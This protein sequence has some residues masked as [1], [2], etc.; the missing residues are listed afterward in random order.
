MRD[1][2]EQQ[3]VAQRR[4]RLLLLCMALS[5]VAMGGIVF[6]ALWAVRSVL[7]LR[8]PPGAPLPP[9]L[10]AGPLFFWSVTV[11][12]VV[13]AIAGLLRTL[14]LR[15]GGSSIAELLDARLVSGQPQDGLDRRLLNVVAE[16]ALAAGAPIPQVYV[17]DRELGI[18]AMAA[19]WDLGDSVICVTRGCLQRL[20]RSELQ[21][22]VAHEFSHLLHGDAR[23]N[24]RLMGAVFGMVSLSLLG[25]QLMRTGSLTAQRGSSLALLGAF[26][27]LVGSVGALLGKLVKA[28]VSRQRE[29]LADAAAVQFTR[30]P[31]GIAGALKKIGGFMFGGR[32]SSTRADEAE[33][34]FLDDTGSAN[35]WAWLTTHPP[36]EERIRR[37][38]PTFDGTF[39][40]PP[41]GLAEAISE[42]SEHASA[43]SA[44]GRP[45]AQKLTAPAQVLPLIGTGKLALESPPINPSVEPTAAAQ[46]APAGRAPIGEPGPGEQPDGG[47]LQELDPVLRAACENAFSA[48]GLVFAL[49]VSADK[50]TSHRQAQRIVDN[51][52]AR[53]LAEAQRLHAAVERAPR[54]VRLTLA[55]VAAPALRSLS[56]RQKQTLRRTVAALI[57]EDG[58]TSVFELV[59]GY[60]LT[61]HWSQPRRLLPKAN[62]GLSAYRRE[63]EL[64]ISCLAHTGATFADSAPRAFEQAVQRLPGLPLSLL[65]QDP[66][67]LPGF[68]TAL[69]EMRALRPTARAALIDACAQATLA[70]GRV[71]EDEVTL[72]R[73]VCLALDAPLP[74][75]LPLHSPAIADSAARPSNDN[76]DDAHSVSA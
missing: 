8:V 4:T 40:T 71:T 60:I 76:D 19:G 65:E 61:E 35:S 72:L 38:L 42:A 10:R 70:D 55:I 2:F 75:L 11:I 51:A 16:M 7:L 20:T 50:N 62:A 67:M 64:V 1:F 73:A 6:G 22:V 69:D 36:L 56:A 39:V 32:L 33:H 52:G 30:N 17:L 59:L 24:L 63:V 53:L 68:T 12:A 34:F 37:L 3:A 49:L 29:Y 41:E 14:S 31:E 57:A 25:K 48:C 58:K 46:E 15:D 28:A 13:V 66:R 47:P 9:M 21:G 26:I 18:N 27:A 74:P 5:V 54:L 45:A 43:A 23:L 44:S